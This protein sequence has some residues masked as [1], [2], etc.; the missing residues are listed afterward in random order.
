VVGGADATGSEPG[1]PGGRHRELGQA[2]PVGKIREGDAPGEVIPG[3]AVPDDDGIGELRYAQ[4]VADRHVL[5]RRLVRPA[6]RLSRR[7]GNR[8]G[9]LVVPA[10]CPLVRTLVSDAIH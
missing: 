10:L 7:L 5:D 4:R 2:G 9:K 3:V 1:A 6:E 8:L